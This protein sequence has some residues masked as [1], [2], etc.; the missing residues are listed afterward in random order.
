MHAR[1][2]ESKTPLDYLIEEESKHPLDAVLEGMPMRDRFALKLYHGLGITRDDISDINFPQ[3]L[4]RAYQFSINLKE[5]LTYIKISRILKISSER[6]RYLV[7][8]GH[9]KIKLNSEI[10]LKEGLDPY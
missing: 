9:W 4:E 8:R 10:R 7:N 2:Y 3:A 6:A 1:L 5:P